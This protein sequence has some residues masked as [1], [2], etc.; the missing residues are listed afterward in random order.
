MKKIFLSKKFYISLICLLAVIS[1]TALIFNG[2][3]KENNSQ[4]KAYT[5]YYKSEQS[6][7]GSYITPSTGNSINI[8]DLYTANGSTITEKSNV[9]VNDQTINIV[10]ALDLYAFSVLAQNN[11]NFLTYNY[12]LLNNIDYSKC[13]YEFIPIA[14]ASGKEF[15]GQFN[16]NGY[17]ISN[18]T[19]LTVAANDF[20]TD[21]FAMFSKLGNG[22]KVTNFGLVNTHIVIN[23]AFENG[24]GVSVAVGLVGEGAEVSYLFARDLRDPI[25]DEAGITAAGGHRIAG[26]VFENKGSLHDCYTAYNII[27]NYTVDD[28]ADFSE[29]LTENSGDIS[30]LFFYDKSIVDYEYD[31]SSKK[32][33][34]VYGNPVDKTFSFDLYYGVYC[35][36][37]SGSIESGLN[38]KVVSSN[39]VWKDET[40]YGDLAGYLSNFLTPITRCITFEKNNINGTYTFNVNN[41]KDFCF[42]FELMNMNANFASNKMIYSIN[43]DLNLQMYSSDSY[44]YK[45]GIG[46]TIVGQ[47]VTG[48]IKLVDDT[49]SNYPTIYNARLKS[50]VTTE[51]IDCYGVFPWVTGSIS[52]LNFVIES[53]EINSSTTDNLKAIGIAFGYCDGATVDNVNVYGNLTID[54]TIGKY[55]VGG[56][57]GVLSGQG[58]ITNS[59]SAGLITIS[60]DT[61]SVNSIIDYMEGC[62]VGGSVGYISSTTGNVNTVL[63]ALNISVVGPNSD[64]AVGGIVGAG[65][66]ND[67]QR[68]ENKG[69]ITVNSAKGSLFV[70]GII[71]RLLGLTTQI[72][73][74]NNV[75]N[76]SVIPH[77]N[78]STYVSGILNADI[79]T[80]KTSYLDLSK[81]KSDNKFYFW[82]SSCT[83][84][85][86]VILNGVSSNLEYTSG[87]NINSKNGFISRLSGI[88]NCS[89]TNP[90][91]IN[92]SYASKY[93]GVLNVIS[94]SNTQNVNISTIYNL[95]NVNFSTTVDINLDTK[96]LYSGCVLGKNIN[97]IDV[98]NEG[99]MIFTPTNSITCSSLTAVG[100]LEEVSSSFSA[101]SIFNGGDISLDSNAIITSNVYFS[102][103]CYANR[104]G[105][106]QSEILM[107]N[108][109]STSFDSGKNGS[110][111][112]VIN[113]GDVTVTNSNYSN[114]EFTYEGIT[115]SNGQQLIGVKYVYNNV[116][117]GHINGNVNISGIAYLNESVI[118]NTFN[119]GNIYNVNYADGSYN[120]LSSGISVL[121][122][123][124]N[125]YILNSANN[126]IIKT[127]NLSTNINAK[128]Y[129][130][131]ISCRNDRNEDET[132]YKGNAN[133]VGQIISFTINY[134][135]IFSYNYANNITSSAD[136]PRTNSSGILSFGLCNIINV[137]NYGNIY[138]SETSSGIFGVVYFQKFSND[139]NSSN[140]VNISNSINYANVYVLEKGE[141]LF[142]DNSSYKLTYS[143]FLNITDSNINSNEEFTVNNVPY[144]MDG[145]NI[146]TENK[147]VKPIYAKLHIERAEGINFYIGSIF[148][149]VNFNND[150]NANNVKIRYLISF[151]ED[152]KIV[153]YEAG[154]P[155]TVECDVSKIYSSYY[156]FIDG[157]DTFSEYMGK[158]V[159]YSPL[160]Q[161]DKNLI[162]ESNYIGVFSEEFEFRKAIEGNLELNITNYPTDK[163]I[164]DY[165]QYVNYKKINPVLLDKIGWRTLAY[166]D[167]AN[168]FAMSLEGTK[169]FYKYYKENISTT[170]YGNDISNAF[171]TGTWSLYA[172]TDT[173]LKSVEEILAD[174]NNVK[175][176]EDII[177]YFFTSEN[178]VLINN[179]FKSKL[180]DYI[181]SLDEN[182][183]ESGDLLTFEYGYSSIL[184][185]IICSDNDNEIKDYIKDKIDTIIQDMNPSSKEDLLIAYNDYLLNNGNE[186]FA[187]TSNTSRYKLLF[188]FFDNIDSDDF[189]VA[190]RSLLKPD[191]ISIID[192]T[193]SDVIKQYDGYNR[194]TEK[195]KKELFESIISSNGED[196]ID[197]YIDKY[198]SEINV[199]NNL[200][201][202]NFDDIFTLID[203][204]STI[205]KNANTISQRVE[206]YNKIKNTSTFSNYIST[207]IT[208]SI[209]DVATEHNN[210]FQSNVAPNNN[211][212]TTANVGYSYTNVV[213]P[214]TY[215]YGPYNDDGSRINTRSYNSSLIFGTTSGNGYY[216]MFM[217]TDED[218]YNEF[219][220]AG[221]IT[222]GT[223][224]RYEYG[225]AN[226]NN[227]FTILGGGLFTGDSEKYIEDFDGNYYV[228][229]FTGCQLKEDISI[230]LIDSSGEEFS[231]AGASISPIYLNSKK[232]S[233]NSTDTTS[234]KYFI[235]DKNGK[236]HLIEDANAKRLDTNSSINNI[237]SWYDLYA[238]YGI[239]YYMATPTNT[240]NS[241]NDYGTGVI[242]NYDN[243]KW[244]TLK[245]A[246]TA[247]KTS[248][249]I[250][251]SA[252]KLILL[253]GV[254]S[255]YG[256]KTTQCEDERNIINRLFNE[257]FLT[258]GNVAKFKKIVKKSLF[259]TLGINSDNTA[260][261]DFINNMIIS[262]I[263][264]SIKI[265]DSAPLSYLSCNIIVEPN[266]YTNVTAYLESKYVANN[267]SNI[268]SAASSNKSVFC[269][270]LDVLFKQTKTIDSGTSNS[271]IAIDGYTPTDLEAP[272]TY[273]GMTYTK[274]FTFN[275]LS[276]DVTSNDKKINIVISNTSGGTKTLSYTFKD[277]NDN[278]LDTDG[279]IDNGI[280]NSGQIS[281]EFKTIQTITID[282]PN[283]T[284]KVEIINEGQ[285]LLIFGIY[286][287]NNTQITYNNSSSIVSTDAYLKTIGGNIYNSSN[288]NSTTSGL[289]ASNGK[290]IYN[291]NAANCFRLPTENELLDAIGTS[292]GN[293]VKIK[294][295]ALNLKV[296]SGSSSSTIYY[297]V[298]STTYYKKGDT[299]SVIFPNQYSG[300]SSSLSPK[301]IDT[302]V[303]NDAKYFLGEVL[304][305]LGNSS[306]VDNWGSSYLNKNIYFTEYELN[307][308]YTTDNTPTEEIKIEYSYEIYRSLLASVEDYS[309]DLINDT[310]KNNENYDDFVK[311][312][313]VYLTPLEAN[314][315]TLVNNYQNSLFNSNFYKLLSIYSNEFMLKI[316]NNLSEENKNLILQYF[317]NNN[318]RFYDS[319]IGSYATLLTDNQ[320]Y[321][322]V[323]A[324]LA[325][326]YKKIYDTS[327]T[328]SNT[329]LSDTLLYTRLSDFDS[330]YQYINSDGSID[331]DKFD[332][333][334]E[335]IGFNT[336]NS[337]YGI[338]ALS[339]SKG[340]L[341][342][343]FI[344]DN[345]VLDNMKA[346][347]NSSFELTDELLPNWRGGTKNSP[348]DISDK[349]SVN[350]AILVEMKQ[351]IKS[352]STT[353]FTLDLIDSKGTTHYSSESTIDLINHTITYYV[354]TNYLDSLTD[355][356]FTIDENTLS[357]ANL[358]TLTIN[359]DK[360]TDGN[361]ILSTGNNENVIHVVAEDKTI[362]VDYSIIFE[363]IDIS[364]DLN[365]NEDNSSDTVIYSDSTIIVKSSG[366]VVALMVTSPSS[367]ELSSNP[368]PKGMDL[369]PYI[370]IKDGDDIV[371]NSFEF[372]VVDNNHIVGEDGSSL[373]IMNILPTLNAGTYDISLNIFGIEKKIS[374]TKEASSECNIISLIYEG[375]ELIGNFNISNELTTKIPFGRAFDSDEFN[376]NNENFYLDSI[377]VSLGATITISASYSTDSNN[378]ATYSVIFTITAEDGSSKVYTHKLVEKNPLTSYDENDNETETKY[379]YATVYKDGN[380]ELTP[381]SVNNPNTIDVTFNRG[382]EPQYRVKYSFTNVYTESEAILKYSL[383]EE[384]SGA[385]TQ[386]T[387]AGM[388][389]TIPSTCD[390][391]EYR[392][393][394][395]Y[396]SQGTWNGEYY[397]REYTFPTLVINKQYSLDATIQKLTFFDS[398]ATLS[399]LAT[400]IQP[401]ISMRPVET[402]ASDEVNY[403][404]YRNKDQTPLIII[405]PTTKYINYKPEDTDYSTKEYNDY[406]SVGAISNANLSDYAPTF[407]IEKHAE[408]YQYT[409]LDKLQKYGAD[410]NQTESDYTILSNHDTLY[411]YV[412][413]VN[414][415]DKSTKIFLVQVDNNG[416]WTNVYSDDGNISTKITTLSENKGDII[417]DGVTYKISE[418]AGTTDSAN[419]SSLFMDYIGTPLDNHFWYVSYV[420]FS[421]D[422]LRSDSK[423]Y[424]KYYHIALIDTS[425]TIYFELTVNTPS[426]FILNSLYITISENIYTTDINSNT[427]I[428]T[429]QI[430]AYVKDSENTNISG[431]KI[432]LLDHNLQ[433]L[434]SG[435]FYF[436]IDLPDGYIATYKV[437]ND[438]DNQNESIDEVGAYLPPTS[439]VTQKIQLTITIE[440]ASSSSDG[441][442]GVSIADIFT[443][444]VNEQVQN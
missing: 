351:L 105:F 425:N 257:Y 361:L 28:Y 44:F 206:L 161:N 97:Y 5:N 287:L 188:N 88:Y 117:T 389:V 317:I 348:N 304:T 428:S 273:Y 301:A 256:D 57:T 286:T 30:N 377:E 281:K 184:A 89:G 55:F 357:I 10:S 48:S 120:L 192:S 69:T 406:F 391:G 119:L 85:G 191:S 18:L 244:F 60:G 90:L 15:T 414:Q 9:T 243:K 216:H 145:N 197:E 172:D 1:I 130:S 280:T 207:I 157:K 154:T 218:I 19:L 277:S 223:I 376:L 295:V 167:A 22:A 430:S 298:S 200:G 212:T 144:G 75:G 95:R 402:T 41:E 342:G 248:Q 128:V 121:N 73:A 54:N 420:V 140:S 49:T 217:T 202:S 124:K 187:N 65:Y 31:D 66:T 228:S 401:E 13:S 375:K 393:Y 394:Y 14:Y 76:I 67:F 221:K 126:G 408:I 160:N 165:F 53:Q 345:I 203:S 362:Y 326:D 104:N 293:N 25:E 308:L 231:T 63:N 180:I 101:T 108:P 316:I 158:K 92:M 372:V 239:D 291:D 387:Y 127:M 164:T 230:S 153:S 368:L 232:T 358:A 405:D 64:L 151:N 133:H 224:Y 349:S 392:Y 441:S 116:P 245:K 366:D 292:K 163:F 168:S 359:E 390:A 136:E 282:I 263:N 240:Y 242:L 29:L 78:N 166:L 329:D 276:F 103:I 438:K 185:N 343:E 443:R 12:Q 226:S 383:S 353:I 314:D 275:S 2:F 265:N 204:S 62:S 332:S 315:S 146:L 379:S 324:Y 8:S 267:K 302:V 222:Q 195:E 241:E 137:V 211:G 284:S 313:I 279:N 208:S 395:T 354:P 58:S 305:I 415:N 247:A 350:Y 320:K 179:T 134:G 311:D 129:S 398:Y 399:N 106:S 112:N 99:N 385:S 325:T 410:K 235:I 374:L 233:F 344:P 52:N 339:S 330:K 27:V 297:V 322:L 249:Y 427:I 36:A 175:S 269:D 123:S 321:I 149:L 435:Y 288:R 39:S 370:S 422:Y 268:I 190:L 386:L 219:Y 442:W 261:I 189:Y 156:K 421:E 423:E 266:T 131:G 310:I 378:I 205:T 397:Y 404:D 45:F 285:N 440:K 114:I 296:Q 11:T 299:E 312:L 196:K 174:S 210:T 369:K 294:S 338:F 255:T 139:V 432:Y 59:T 352:I 364:F 96:L 109:L 412:P 74:L 436:Y 87:I 132:D 380:V 61:S 300:S 138:S 100:V 260:N 411:I 162:G 159:T 283:N 437:T 186:F 102:G 122:V 152:I 333:F 83:N 270:L 82:A 388:I 47:N 400:I 433:V 42:I 142:Y 80:T 181:L 371:D 7:I 337:G 360:L 416:K 135:S 98:R 141:N 309:L 125:A 225:T 37:I 170:N 417:Y 20:N 331:N 16:G 419:N 409:T 23:R 227:Q 246:S 113:N 251:Y 407:I 367:T 229:D 318:Y 171:L 17:E 262:N 253:D 328:S 363:E 444:Q 356:I 213:T 176:I 68:L 38:E 34:I 24:Q 335:L 382:E 341:N 86:D 84:Y 429:K 381:D 334:A 403:F 434:P 439:I 46:A 272:I 56:I 431:Q 290:V 259:E 303:I 6:E 396:S 373:I 147:K 418:Y 183:L 178:K 3:Q 278:I 426:D 51:G 77:A 252:S 35:S 71:G 150:T 384:T 32:Y 199:Y 347:Y 40:Y 319:F 346:G 306:E 365:Y 327:L 173:L 177:S 193:V 93:S 107:F 336:S 26:L 169:L 148:S 424:C 307:I 236:K 355:K 182:I 91:E 33:N 79:V 94:T 237:A 194:L 250:K 264:S 209:L 70:S 234:G 110:L 155:S 413:Y 323:S 21:Y 201:I 118:T 50:Y 274:S 258:S 115:S 289:S 271:Q 4:F 81:L 214:S 238:T 111:N 43:S 254:Y 72:N 340:I 198:G 220:E 215:F 143:N